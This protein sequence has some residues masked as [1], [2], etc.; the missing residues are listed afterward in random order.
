MRKF[1]IAL[2]FF[3]LVST[4]SWADFRSILIEGLHDQITTAL[5]KEFPKPTHI[6]MCSVKVSKSLNKARSQPVADLKLTCDGKVIFS[7]SVSKMYGSEEMNPREQ[8]DIN[9]EIVTAISAI[10]YDTKKMR[11][12]QTCNI[13][14]V[15]VEGQPQTRW[16][17]LFVGP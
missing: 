16:I 9:D 13:K 4:N 15:D 2:F 10:L 6:S 17:C 5:Q 1:S 3:S 11:V 8:D 14:Q 7:E 12:S